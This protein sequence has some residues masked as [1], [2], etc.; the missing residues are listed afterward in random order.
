MKTLVSIVGCAEYNQA[1]VDLAV[2]QAC[3]TADFPD[4]SGKS[5]LLKPNILM[6][7]DPDRAVSTHPQVMRSAIR[8]VKSRG[9]A[10]VLI[11][12]SPGFQVGTATF[13]KS[14]IFQAAAEEGAEWVDFSEGLQVDNPGGKVVKSFTIAKAAV[15]ADILVSMCKLKNHTLMYF[16]GAMKN[17]LGCVP[18]LLKPQFHMRFPDRLRFGQMLTDLNLALRSDF[19]IMDA[20]VG[21]EGPGPGSGYP[22]AVGA[23]LASADPLALDRTACRII[24]LDPDLVANLED[25]K[26]RG[27]W[28]SSDAEIEIVGT[29]PED[30]VVEDWK[31]VPRVAVSERKIPPVFRNLFVSRP[32]FSRTKCVACKACVTICPVQALE[33]V[34]DPKAKVKKSVRVNYDTCIRCYCCHEVCA[35][36]AIIVKRRRPIGF[37]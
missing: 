9:A 30:I 3:D 35:D 24:N 17:L 11:G 28:I 33:L 19:S 21:M 37:R 4:V 16:T 32:F 1:T 34:P 6:G 31:H 23:I 15:E 2:K 27:V 29:Q 36:D 5:V 7:A 10:R 22:R 25:A 13:K 12:E 14:G 18:G 20:I 8:Y 26:G